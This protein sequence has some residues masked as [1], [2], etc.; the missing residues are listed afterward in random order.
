[1]INLLLLL[2]FGM[3]LAFVI[4]K[5]F[6][7][8]FPPFVF[9]L[10]IGLYG[11]AILKKSHHAFLLSLFA[12]ATIWIFYIIKE[13]RIF[14]SL[15]DIKNK[16]RS[17]PVGFLC[18]LLV[19]L[20]MLYCYHNHFVLGWDDFHY[21]ATFPKDMYYY[22]TMPVG[23]NSATGYKDYLP[24]LQL[25]YY[26]GFQGIRSFSEPL[27]FQYKIV[28]AYTCMLPF[29]KMMNTTKGFK[30]ASI[31]II[32]V[33]L[34]YISL[35]EILDSLSMDAIMGLLFGYV[36]I[37]A[38]LEKKRDWFCYYR[39]LVA[40]LSLMLIKSIAAMFVG[41]CIGVWFFA[42]VCARKELEKK[43]LL[44]R[45]GIFIG[46]CFAVAGA[47][48]SWKIFCMRNG[49]STYLK[50]KLLENLNTSGGVQL[51]LYGPDTI[52]AF[53]ES[54][55]T[56]SLNFGRFGL[57]LMGTLL[58][59]LLL[60][61]V[62]I[63]KKKFT[64]SDFWCY[65]L[66]FAGLA[67]YLVFLCYTYLFIFE[68]WEAESLSSLDRYLGTYVLTLLFV[69]LYHYLFRNPWKDAGIYVI[70]LVLL[71][72]LN[73]P[74]LYTA[75][76]PSA[77]MEARRDA[78]EAK[79]L[80]ENEVEQLNHRRLEMKKMLVVNNTGNDVYSRSIDYCMIP[81]VTE[82][83]LTTDFT[84]DELV[85]AMFQKIVDRNIYYVYFT[86]QLGADEDFS[87]FNEAVDDNHVRSH[88]IYYYDQETGKLKLAE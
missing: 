86:E 28:L 87:V 14:P 12:F 82:P 41:I 25:F 18:Y 78:H 58:L 1:M 85:N 69:V 38:A 7:D 63:W 11:L 47:Y 35:I 33:I 72:T 81:F 88:V 75:L 19:C 5:D 22:G 16:F 56:L 71:A 62:L 46:S 60:C 40:L 8:I 21:N 77:Y 43:E 31:L 68:P 23:N 3:L 52:D 32:S 2:F 59:V 55:F 84:K 80:A 13:K 54:L 79:Q 67:V 70:T 53:I 17:L 51:P 50:Q 9:T 26:W 4:N 36:I 74:M 76:V 39:I 15:K 6:E 49:N 29:F 37:M 65:A 30:R 45:A 20:V 83:L 48:L 73:Y 66:L 34:P 61:V 44:K 10:L 42:E 57:T 24:L 64:R 27:M